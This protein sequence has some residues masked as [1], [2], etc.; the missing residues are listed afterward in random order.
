MD[1]RK[2]GV[3]GC[4]LMGSGI[5]QVAASAGFDVTV[6][7]VEQRFLD[8]GFASIEKSLAKFAEKPEKSGITSEKAKEIRGR[9]KGTTNR[10]DLADCDIIVE[11]I[12]ENI[13][14]KKEIY[15]ALDKIAKREAIF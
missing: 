6:L 11:A 9:L 1:I 7:E 5:A 4:G 14:A 8:N 10:P 12:I 2:V 15:A 13:E 3:L